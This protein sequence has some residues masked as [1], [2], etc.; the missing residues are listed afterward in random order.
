MK[1][2]RKTKAQLAQELEAL[3]RINHTIGTTFDPHEILQGIINEIVPLFAAQSGSV[4]LLDTTTKRA[5]L[6]TTYGGKAA[7]GR[8]IR[9]P[10]AG[11]LSGWV[12]EQQRPLRVPCLT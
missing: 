7:G 10:W 12:A 9:Y 2:S 11:T 4:I 3:R 8:T 6:T 1:S 5:E